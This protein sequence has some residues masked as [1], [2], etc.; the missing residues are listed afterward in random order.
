MKTFSI[1]TMALLGQITALKLFQS[2]MMYYGMS[3]E[4]TRWI[5]GPIGFFM[6][7]D[8]FWYFTPEENKQQFKDTWL[9]KKDNK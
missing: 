1:I 8:L 4:A 2:V 6:M 5:I 7:I 3:F 9:P